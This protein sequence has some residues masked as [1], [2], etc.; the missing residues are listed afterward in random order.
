M[1]RFKMGWGTGEIVVILLS[2]ISYFFD[3]TGA[4]YT[5]SLFLLLSGAWTLLAG[6]AIVERR[7]RTYYASWGVVLAVLSSFAFLPANY[8]IGLVLVAIVALILLTALN[9][10]AG[11]MV[12]AASQRSPSARGETPAAGRPYTTSS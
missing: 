1:A 10:G 11:K 12:T 8:A 9:Y 7:D 4:K 2:L 6:L 5:L 3:L